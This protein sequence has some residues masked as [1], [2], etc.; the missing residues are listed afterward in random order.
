MDVYLG[1][2][3]F[4]PV[5]AVISRNVETRAA[6]HGSGFNQLDR[7]TPAPVTRGEARAI[8]EAL[9]ARNPGFEIIRHSVSPAHSYDDDALEWGDAWLRQ[10]GH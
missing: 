8:E 7:L 4:K 9:I 1:V 2:R 10:Q 5:Y 6:R 3:D